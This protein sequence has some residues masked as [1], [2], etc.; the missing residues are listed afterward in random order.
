MFFIIINL[1][2]FITGAAVAST[3]SDSGLAS[4][5]TIIFL[6][7]WHIFNSCGIVAMA[8]LFFYRRKKK[9]ARVDELNDINEQKTVVQQLGYQGTLISAGRKYKANTSISFIRKS[10]EMQTRTKSPQLEITE[11]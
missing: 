7:F 10:S 4:D 5:G 2:S 11:C 3:T 6:I 1:F 8:L 9:P